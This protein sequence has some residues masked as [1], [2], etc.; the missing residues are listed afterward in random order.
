MS[1]AGD[2]RGHDAAAQA[3]AG[4][5]TDPD[6]QR[7]PGA[8][9]ATW[10]RRSFRLLRGAGPR[11]GGRRGCVTS[12]RGGVCEACRLSSRVRIVREPS[13][14]RTLQACTSPRCTL[15]PDVQAAWADGAV[16][17]DAASISEVAA[18]S[19]AIRMERAGRALLTGVMVLLY[20]GRIAQKQK[21]PVAEGLGG[22]QIAREV[23]AA[24]SSPGDPV[25]AAAGRQGAMN[26]AAPT[27]V[28]PLRVRA[29]AEA[30][31]R[32]LVGR[33]DAV[34]REDQWS[35][36]EALAVHRRRALVVQRTGWGKSA[37]YFVATLLLREQGAGPTVIVSPLLALMRNQIAAAE[38][39]GIRAVTINS[40]NI[41]DWEPIQDAIRAG[42]V[43]VLLVSPERLNN[44]GFRDEVLP[45]AGRD[46]RAP[47]RRRGPLH[48]RLGP[49]LPARLPPDPHPA[50]RPARRHPGAR[51]HG[52]RQRPGHRRRR[53]AARQRRRPRQRRP[54]AARLPRPRVAAARRGPAQ[55]RPAA[56]GLAGRPPGRAARLRHRL[57]PDRRRHPGDRRLPALARPRRRGL[58]RPDRDHRAA[59]ARA[60][61][62]RRSG[63]GADRHQRARH[64]LRRHPRLRR[65]HGC[66]GRR[67]SPTT[68]RSAAPAVAPTRPPWCCCR[69]SRTATSGP[70][71][72]RW[73]SR[74]RSRSARP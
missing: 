70:T 29:N 19:P 5:L 57:L 23:V 24:G 55:D 60:G 53:R 11:R 25:S 16:S 51:D 68:S 7:Q 62:R 69:R 59:G 72:P 14:L 48:L 40:T 18:P 61:P 64:G 6:R 35:A 43:D 8:S 71:S 73:P 37:V 33:D 39:A 31:L 34:L 45:R 36:I 42:E 1:A 32:A 52:D 54:R 56:A 9:A 27:D 67:R 46:L 4:R 20:P 3:L 15:A 66:A 74:A 17:T 10:C 58:L 65:Q 47:G 63:Q 28:R 13:S 49:R 38:R 26:A 50:R 12:R 44:P 41:E 2:L 22:V 30:H 21:Q